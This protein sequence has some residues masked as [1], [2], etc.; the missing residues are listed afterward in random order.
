MTASNLDIMQQAMTAIVENGRVDQIDDLLAADF[1][2]HDTMENTFTRDD[3]RMGVLEMLGAFSDR[4]LQIADQIASGDK[5]VTRWVATGRHTG[6]Y[7]GIPATGRA[8]RL[9]GISIDRLASGKIIESW[10]VTDDLG[11]LQQLGVAPGMAAPS[12]VPAD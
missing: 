12:A 4:Q 5:V 7:R 1:V 9:T 11:L 10:E 6:G 3:F 2:G 8:F